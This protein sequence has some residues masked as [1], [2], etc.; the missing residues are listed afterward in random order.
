LGAFF[1]SDISFNI[2]E[3]HQPGFEK[4]VERALPNSG[5]PR[6]ETEEMNKGRDLLT[7]FAP[8][9]EQ[10]GIYLFILNLITP[11]KLKRLHLQLLP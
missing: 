3:R 9:Y 1:C 5:L 10:V 7:S 8:K 11:L 2:K 4:V 6:S